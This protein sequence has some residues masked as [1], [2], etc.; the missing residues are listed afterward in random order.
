MPHLSF[1][2]RQSKKEPKLGTIYALEI[3]G[4]NVL[5]RQSLKEVIPMQH[6]NSTAQTVLH[7][8]P[9]AR[10]LNEIIQFKREKYQRITT[11]YGQDNDEVCFLTYFEN[12]LETLKDFQLT[13]ASYIKYLTVLNKLRG[14][15]W[16]EF[17]KNELNIADLRS[18]EVL[19]GIKNALNSPKSKHAL[20][21]TASIKSY[22]SVIGSFIKHWNLD[23]RTHFPINTQIL[24]TNL[25]KQSKKLAVTLTKGQIDSIKALEPI[26]KRG[27]VSIERAKATFLFQYYC[28]GIRIQDALLLTN[29][30]IQEDAIRVKIKK[31]NDL[32]EFP[33]LF[34]MAEALR[35]LYPSQFNAANK[36]VLLKDLQIANNE[37]ITILR[38]MKGQDVS[39]YSMSDTHNLLKQVSVVNEPE[40]IVVTRALKVVLGLFKDEITKLF[41]LLISKEPKMF[42]LPYLNNVDFTAFLEKGDV[43]TP[44]QAYK[45]HKATAAHNSTLKRIANLLDL[46]NI[47]SHTPRH[48]LASHMLNG[49]ASSTDI[50]LTLAHAHLA[51]TEH[52]LKNRHSS[53]RRVEILKKMHG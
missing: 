30:D 46:P 21:S 48:T 17:K 15:V 47:S 40:G 10:E 13:Y 1:Y 2:I 37:M 29:R 14:I 26:G 11:N 6:W 19:L 43:L 52:Y 18:P 31:T 49:G 51:T 12:K 24:M 35:P 9:R 34:E 32:I 5:R 3:D 22:L 7:K 39:N 45:A 42:L 41:F 53:K 36:Q 20:S 16:T 50:S 38:I 8:N 4:P 28:G 33:L 44:K 27:G 25:R 23:S